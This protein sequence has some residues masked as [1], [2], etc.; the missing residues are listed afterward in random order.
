MA[1]VHLSTDSQTQVDTPY[2]AHRASKHNS[3]VDGHPQEAYQAYRGPKL[4]S[5]L[6]HWPQLVCAIP[7]NHIHGIHARLAL[8]IDVSHIGQE[9]ER[10]N[11]GADCLVKQELDEDIGLAERLLGGVRLGAWLFERWR[12]GRH[13]GWELVLEEA[14]P[15]DIGR[16][17]EDAE[18]GELEDLGVIEGEWRLWDVLI[19]YSLVL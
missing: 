12:C 9:H 17:T 2:H 3:L 14:L 16:V 8:G 10:V 15:Y 19:A 13:V 1:H 18:E 11:H 5:I 4:V 6:D 7:G